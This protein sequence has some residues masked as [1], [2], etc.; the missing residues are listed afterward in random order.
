MKTV[1]YARWFAAFI[2][3]TLFAKIEIS[4]KASHG[5][6]N[7]LPTSSSVDLIY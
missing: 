1:G 5:K 6:G 7:G 2:G 4:L 3:S